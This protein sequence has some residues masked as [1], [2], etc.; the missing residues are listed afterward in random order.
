MNEESIFVAALERTTASERGAFLDG[1]CAGDV[2]LRQRVERLLSA[3]SATL[4]ILDQPVRPP[5]W[6]EVAEGLGPVGGAPA[7]SAGAL[8]ADRYRLIEEIGAGGM[9]TVWKAEQTQPVRRTVAVKLIRA[10]M[11]TRS[12]LSRFEA[13]RQA[14]ALMEHPNIA[15]VLDGG[16]TE[17]GRPF[18]VMEYVE[19]VDL[20]R[21]C[22][23]ARLN[24]ADRL[25]L[26]LPVCQAVQHAHTKGVVHRDLKPGNILISLSDGRPMPKVIDFGLAKAMQQPLTE[27][28]LHTAHGALLGTPL[29]M[30]PEQAEPNN[31]DV[32]ARADVYA[33]GVILYELLTGT[34]PLERRRFYEAA[35]HEG[36]RLIRE[37]EPPPPSARLGD[38][39]SLPSL[40]ALRR[41]EPA[42]LTRTV[43]GELDWIVMKCLEKDRAR[44]YGTADGLARDV[45]R[46]LA[47]ESVEACPPSAGYRLVKFLRRN[48]GPVLAASVI[49]LLL[50]AGIAGTTWGMLRAD[51][52]LKAE[53]ARALGE[54]RANQSAQKRL[55]QIEAGSRILASIFEDLDPH[56]EE[57][58]SRP[59][60]AILG[61]RLD[62]AAAGLDGDAVGD[63]LLVATLQDRL[64]R[65]YR[66]LGH[67]ARAKAM[68]A[69]ALAARRARL[70]DENAD[71]LAVMSHQASALADTGDLA[72]AISLYEQVR[73]AQSRVLGAE[74]RDTLATGGAL[75]MAYWKTGRSSEACKLL[76][77]VRDSLSAKYGADDPQTVDALYNLSA[78]Y[79]IVGKGPEAIALAE[80][81]RDARV[82]R[83]GADHPLA[84]ESLNNLASRY[85]GAGKMRQALALFEEA[86]DGVVARLGAEHPASLG[87]LDNLARMYRAFG[88]SAE[89]VSL[90]QQVRDARVMT[91]GPYHP[92]SI[93]TTH[94]LGA[95]YQA[96]GEPEKALDTYRQAATGLERINFAHAGAYLII[97]DLCDRLEERQQFDRADVW[98]KKWLA[99]VKE[100]DGADSV[101][102][103]SEL[104]RLGDDLLQRGRHAIAEPILRECLTILQARQPEGLTTFLAQS[105]LG[106][107]LLEQKKYAEAEPLLVQGYEGLHALKGQIAPL[108]ARYRM[109]EAGKR[110][111]RLYEDSGQAE[112]AAEWR[113]KLAGLGRPVPGRGAHPKRPAKAG[114]P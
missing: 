92:D 85:Q 38:S 35:W 25:A 114:H 12:V 65:T 11:D 39:E 13:E 5:G 22:D 74:H 106:G 75:A 64:G 29:Y 90:A 96:A 50:V 47:D 95:A 69:K 66:A 21:Y 44:R 102:Y 63:P 70:G 104:A 84:I 4:G 110:V 9:G 58:E 26:F 45:Q 57:K 32:D 31:P 52:A 86:R 37:E 10:G 76:E 81:V 62:R 60:R 93:Y 78:V 109:G 82:K 68:F 83:H 14:L 91:L 46:Y 59:L 23:D 53:T 2:G 3:H 48:R 55:Q 101:A 97:W 42:R 100:R 8:I 94:N 73:G 15:R 98:R 71:T 80:Q 16:T 108:Y 24:I 89:S 113:A 51:R 40:A 27:R 77:R 6:T 30:S 1:A 111:V 99:A 112:K 56:A 36:L 18:F 43:R 103:A 88:R 7:E 19:G 87:I 105:S 107:V 49:F 72:G 28:T 79:E 61:D 34:T 41:L 33:L 54:W 67:V 17:S 20:T